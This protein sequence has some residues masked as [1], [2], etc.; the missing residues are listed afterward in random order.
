MECESKQMQ[1]L[2]VVKHY[3]CWNFKAI[4]CEIDSFSRQTNK[5]LVDKFARLRVTEQQVREN[6]LHLSLR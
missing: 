4:R 6:Q 5:L 2:C 3:G 1:R